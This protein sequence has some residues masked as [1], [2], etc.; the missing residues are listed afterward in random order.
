SQM[1][2]M[3]IRCSGQGACEATIVFRLCIGL[4][5]GLVIFAMPGAGVAGDA[6]VVSVA[7]HDITV[8]LKPTRHSLEVTDTITVPPTVAASGSLQFLL[9]ESLVIDP[10]ADHIER[11]ASVGDD[12]KNMVS[13]A[14]VP[15]AH[16]RLRLRNNQTQVIIKYHGEIHHPLGESNSGTPG[17][18]SE[19]GIFLASSSAWY[20]LLQNNPLITFTMNVQL[21]T[22]WGA[23]SQGGLKADSETSG[24]QMIWSET[25]PQDDIYLVASKYHQY[26][27]Q[28]AIVDAMVFLRQP[29]SD[30]AQRYL[31]ATEQYIAMYDQLIGTYPYDKFALVENFWETGYGMPSFTL[32]GSRVLRL[33]FIIYTS[34]PHEIVHNYWGN[35]VY[36]DYQSGNWAEGLTAYLADHLL[37]EQRGQGAQY[38]RSM[39]QKY[40]D[41]VNEGRD[42]PLTEFRSRHDSATEAVGYGKTLMLFHMLRV[43]LGK[44]TFLDAIRA[45]Y[46][47]YKFRIAAF[48]DIQRVF[49][50][51]ANKNLDVFFDQWVQRAGAPQLAVANVQQQPEAAGKEYRIRFT[52]KQLQS[53]PAFQIDVPVIVYLEGQARPYELMVSMASKEQPYAIRVPGKALA[54]DV[55][56]RFDVFR[57]LDHRE[58]P[59][60]ISQG[61]GAEKPM[62]VIPSNGDSNMKKEYEALANQWQQRY[63][64]SVQI[65]NADS[66]ETLPRDRTVWL[67]GWNNRFRDE[68]RDALA[69]NKVTIGENSFI[70]DGKRYDT[71]DHSALF[72][73]R[74]PQNQANTLLWLTASS[75]EAV[76]G[77][78]RKLPH[79]GKYSYL[80]FKGS[81]PDNIVK[82]QWTVKDSPM[83]AVLD[84]TMFDPSIAPQPHQA[85]MMPSRASR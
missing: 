54:L 51:V 30:V 82:G 2:K 4:I 7:H 23:V 50:R 52:L 59:A 17:L 78:A 40:T 67:L 83:R 5:A 25:H 20:P 47:Q 84:K 63:L 24:R 64:P 65:V 13:H 11:L 60:A 32:L 39:L 74:H 77:L 53:E 46:Q 41:F 68:L 79:Y 31:K 73:A 6:H 72:A 43:H 80:V 38:R 9:H 21:P 35:G 12:F 33:P 61:F 45:L 56:P 81:A 1:K 16:Y 44:D 14:T 37:K 22:G 70:V 71:S 69:A 75:P 57:R 27:Q 62:L 58:I 76:A 15:L 48:S 18:I 10:S 26:R 19:Q 55:D 28:S 85:L 66:L 8:S 42:F 3:D 34:Y 36:V 29:D 49:N